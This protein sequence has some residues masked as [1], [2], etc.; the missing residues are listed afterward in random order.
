MS[1]SYINY[2][3]ELKKVKDPQRLNGRDAD[4]AYAIVQTDLKDSE[5]GLT[6][7]SAYVFA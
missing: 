5:R 1:Y 7:P 2:S 4:N 6:R 3:G